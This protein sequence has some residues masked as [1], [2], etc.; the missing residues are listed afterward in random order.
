M[1]FRLAVMAGDDEEEGAGDPFRG[2][3][4]VFCWW[5]GDGGLRR[6][7]G[8]ENGM[9]SHV[10][11]GSNDIARSK[12]FYDAVFGAMGGKPAA[13]DA[14]GRLIYMHNGGLFIVSAPIDGKAATH[15]NGGTIVSRWQARNRPPRGTRRGSRTAARRSR[16]R[17]AFARAAPARCI[18]PTFAIP[19]ATNC[20]R[21]IACRLAELTRT[22]TERTARCGGPCARILLDIG[23]ASQR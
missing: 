9:F 7:Y 8:G 4:T 2:P 18:L 17:R 13:Q 21:C 15:A 12:K 1:R 10:M 6:L 23:G 20:A 16:T 5:R 19:T 22:K 14:K 3:Q 11:V